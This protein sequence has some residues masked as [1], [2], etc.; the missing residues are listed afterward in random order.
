MRLYLIKKAPERL[1]EHLAAI[2]RLTDSLNALVSDLLM[3]SRLELG[4]LTTE[5]VLLNLNEVLTRVIETHE[6][7]AQSK[8]IAL[9]FEPAPEITLIRVDERQIERAVMNLVTNAL[10]Y[11]PVGGAVRLASHSAREQVIFTVQDTGIGISPQAVPH[12]FERFYRSGEAKRMTEG[13]GLG[14][15]I[16]KEIVEKHGGYIVVESTLG[17]G[18]R[19]TVYLPA[20]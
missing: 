10:N 4:V 13:T 19:F 15:S 2:E 3:L 17:E 8:G 20:V 1:P 18:S 7:I 16:T 5:L 9:T 11:T 14:L 12:I 6:Y